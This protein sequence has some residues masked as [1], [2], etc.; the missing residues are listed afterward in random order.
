MLTGGRQT[1]LSV[2][3]NQPPLQI[4]TLAPIEEAYSMP[5]DMG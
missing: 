2:C 3:L 5:M 4:I 1:R